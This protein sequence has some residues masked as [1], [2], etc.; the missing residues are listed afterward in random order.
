MVV[1]RLVAGCL[2]LRGH[3]SMAAQI[4]GPFG[5]VMDGH[6]VA[7]SNQRGFHRALVFRM[8]AERHGRAGSLVGHCQ[9]GITLDGE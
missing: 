9:H 2:F 6:P 4:H 7:S 8:V 1:G 5:V 3:P